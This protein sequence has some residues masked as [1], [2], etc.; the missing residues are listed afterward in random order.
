VT[1]ARAARTAGFDVM[2]APEQPL[3]PVGAPDA[4]AATVRLYAGIGATGLSL[5]FRHRS[6]AHYQE[7]LAAMAAVTADVA[8]RG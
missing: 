8:R 6:R 3:D 1:D 4:A 2:L 7:Q 5:R